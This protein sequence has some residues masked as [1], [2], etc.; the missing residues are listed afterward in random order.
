MVASH[1]PRP[2]TGDGSARRHPP[3]GDAVAGASPDRRLRLVVDN[4]RGRPWPSGDVGDAVP[5]SVNRSEPVGEVVHDFGGLGLGADIARVLPTVVVACLMVFGALVGLRLIQGEEGIAASSA[6]SVEA[7]A[8]FEVTAS[9]DG[10]MV[11]DPGAIIVDAPGESLWSIAAERFPESDTR[12]VVDL[13]VEAN[14]GTVIQAGQQL[15]V[16]AELQSA[17]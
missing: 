6:R 9:G 4:T 10:P 2:S 16:P 17:G 11:A 8:S 1:L 13:L 12:W 14:G 3:A 15:R 7:A 5:R